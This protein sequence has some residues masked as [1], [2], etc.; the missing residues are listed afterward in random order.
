MAGPEKG[1]CEN[2]T[3]FATGSSLEGQNHPQL[4]LGISNPEKFRKVTHN[5]FSFRLLA[6]FFVLLSLQTCQDLAMSGAVLHGE[7]TQKLAEAINL[8]NVTMVGKHGA[9]AAYT[10]LGTLCP[11]ARVLSLAALLL[12]ECPRGKEEDLE[13]V[14]S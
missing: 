14:S 3:G 11:M 5:E 8:H 2:P 13:G 1:D 12:E 10:L 7:L 4:C 9:H 6:F